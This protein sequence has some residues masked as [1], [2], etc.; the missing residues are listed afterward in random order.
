MT[1][2]ATSPPALGDLQASLVRTLTPVVVGTL[3]GGV[4]R[5]RL[6]DEHAKQLSGVIEPIAIM[7]YYGLVRVL[8]RRVGRGFGWLIGYARSP[9]YPGKDLQPDVLPGVDEA[10]DACQA[11]GTHV[12]V[13]GRGSLLL[14]GRRLGGLTSLSWADGPDG[15]QLTLVLTSPTVVVGLPAALPDGAGPLDQAVVVPAPSR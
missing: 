8:E 13:D 5:S 9:G 6:D 4:L 14:D 12:L 3:L 7:A 11:P 1:A 2:P 15:P 10:L